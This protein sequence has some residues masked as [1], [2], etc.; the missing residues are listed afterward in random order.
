MFPDASPNSMRAMFQ[1]STALTWRCRADLSRLAE[2]S[3]VRTSRPLP[4]LGLGLALAPGSSFTREV[5]SRNGSVAG[6]D[7]EWLSGASVSETWNEQI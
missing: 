1:R 4:G 7:A 3:S 2:M 6:A 5:E